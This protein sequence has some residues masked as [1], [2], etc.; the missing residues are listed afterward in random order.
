[1]KTVPDISY[2]VSAYN[3]PVMLPVVLWAIK[4]Q[5]HQNFEVFVTDNSTD[6][7]TV[8]HH[9]ESVA[10]LKDPRFKHIHTAKKIK[11][12]EC[13]WAAEYALKRA[14][15]QWFCF[16]C[17]DTY[18]VPEF[19]ARMLA[20]GVQDCLDLVY[21][22]EVLVGPAAAGGS[23]YR[24]WFQQIGRT[25]KTSFIVRASSF[26][27]FNKPGLVCAVAVDYV[28]SDEMYRAGKKV[29]SV[30]ECMVVHN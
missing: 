28:F 8:E 4:G 10:Q 11:V 22:E 19:G 3:R 14:R 17:D 24:V 9:K 12:S 23:G 21:C 6:P 5:S 7:K 29:G 27:G 2:I 1:M 16:P 18:L 20:K 13:Y 26:P 30:R 15:G 25:V